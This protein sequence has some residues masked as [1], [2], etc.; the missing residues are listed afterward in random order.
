MPGRVRG[1][2]TQSSSDPLGSHC[3]EAPLPRMPPR[4]V[5]PDEVAFYQE[6]GYVIIRNF[7]QTEEEL[8]HWR[9]GV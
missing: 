2:R 8:E 5:T 1:K 6:N 3:A 4:D 9:N 7:L